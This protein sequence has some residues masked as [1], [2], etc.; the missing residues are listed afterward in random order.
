MLGNIAQSYHA[1]GR[2]S[3]I[4]MDYRTIPSLDRLHTKRC[5]AGR[6]R[7]DR[8]Y[9]KCSC[10][11]HVEGK[12]GDQFIRKSLQASNWQRAQQRIMEAEARGSWEPLPGEAADLITIAEA[13]DKFL[14]DAESGRRLGE[15][16]LKKYKL[17]LRHL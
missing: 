10:P 8:S 4:S 11:I 16:T 1:A 12:C 14:K 9:R 5:T 15:S 13:K 2:E 6:S 7:L 3:Q 17:M